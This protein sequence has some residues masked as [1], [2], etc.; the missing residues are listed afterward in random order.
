MSPVRNENLIF[1]SPRQKSND[2][3]EEENPYGR[4]T[5]NINAQNYSLTRLLSYF[6]KR[7]LSA[8]P[9]NQKKTVTNSIKNQSY[10]HPTTLVN[11]SNFTEIRSSLTFDSSGKCTNAFKTLITSQMLKTAYETI[12]SSPGNMVH[13][14]DKQTLDKITPA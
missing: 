5:H 9:I 12:K 1:L 14:S 6:I 3:A 7:I 13:G 10:I 4:K 11:K 8:T 2:V